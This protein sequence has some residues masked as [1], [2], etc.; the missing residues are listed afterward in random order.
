MS[1]LITVDQ[2]AKH[3]SISVQSI[4][5]MIQKERIDSIKMF[6]RI[7]IPKDEVTRVKRLRSRRL[8]K[9]NGHK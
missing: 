8:K 1:E 4:Y 7:V 3:L 2:A 5:L 9:S 6:G